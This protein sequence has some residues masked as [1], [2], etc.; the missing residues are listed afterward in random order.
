MLLEGQRSP[1][2]Q[3]ALSII[4][5]DTVTRLPVR[6]RGDT[7]KTKREIYCE[8]FG[9]EA[10]FGKEEK[11]QGQSVHI[12]GYYEK[13]NIL[14]SEQIDAI[15]E[16]QTIL[17]ASATIGIYIPLLVEAALINAAFDAK[18]THQNGRRV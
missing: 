12:P 9:P 8:V 15:L 14:S 3:K 5:N 10:K 11:Q 4:E 16:E 13:Y 18:V 6:Y 2:I 7:T 1:R 17:L